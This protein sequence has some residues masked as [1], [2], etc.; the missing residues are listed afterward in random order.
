MIT[1]LIGLMLQ[2]G[3]ASVTAAPSKVDAGEQKVC[4]RYVET[5]SFVR[6]TKVCRTRSEWRRTEEDSKAEGRQMQNNPN[7]NQGG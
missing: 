7:P 5:G 4:R 6:A 3:S 1:I 2:S